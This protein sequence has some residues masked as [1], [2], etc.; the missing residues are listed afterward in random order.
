[1]GAK[2]RQTFSK[3]ARERAVQE[4]RARKQE[5]KEERKQAAAE[6]AEGGDPTEAVPA[7]DEPDSGSLPP[8]ETPR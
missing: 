5:K 7:E 6:L 3:M 8:G 4:K 1:M 2:K